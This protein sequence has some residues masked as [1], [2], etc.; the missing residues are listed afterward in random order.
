MQRKRKRKPIRITWQREA[1]RD[2][3]LCDDIFLRVALY[4]R[5]EV[6][7]AILEPL[8]GKKDIE[9]VKL[10]VQKHSEL[11]GG[12]SVVFD[13]I[14]KTVDGIVY[15]VE[16][17]RWAPDAP[18]RRMRY[19]ASMLDASSLKKG[20]T[21][22]ALPHCVV[23]FI[24]DADYGKTGEPLYHV[25]RY[26]QE[27]GTVFDDG[28]EIL[29]AN[30]GNEDTVSEIGC[31]MHDMKAVDPVE[32]INPILSDAVDRIKYDRGDKTVDE[33][34]ERFVSSE[35]GKAEARG[36]QKGIEKGARDAIVSL[37]LDGIIGEEVAAQ[38]LG[39]TAEEF[40]EIVRAQRKA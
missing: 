37:F 22:D 7:K 19:Y 14:I 3:A 1:L 11:A 34:M 5:P 31:L 26:Y 30:L 32:M 28:Q 24:V 18:T 2:K 12:H 15:N 29:I 6:A 25:C 36:I 13:A 20:L 35:L 33:A 8:L 21:Y 40:R 10:E 23:I 27:N 39:M 17:Q 4:K 9:V 38:R 16:V